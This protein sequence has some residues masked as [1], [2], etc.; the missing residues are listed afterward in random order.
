[1][2][3]GSLK[4][5]YIARLDARPFREVQQIES[6]ETTRVRDIVEAPDGSIWFVSA[7]EGA[8]FRLTP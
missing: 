2:F 5:D 8:I 6:D 1:M 3:V 4:F 7:G